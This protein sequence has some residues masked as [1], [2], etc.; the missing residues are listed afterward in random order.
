MN[1]SLAR[2]LA[3]A[4]G[5]VVALPVLSEAQLTRGIISGT[6]R[7][8]TSA[9]VPGAVATAINVATGVTRSAVTND[10][11]FY[12]IPALEP[13]QYL[14]KIELSGFK[15]V[16][17]TGVTVPM[18]TEVTVSVGLEVA[19]LGEAVTVTGEAEAVQLNKS[20]P[21]VGQIS[22][23]RQAVEL[24]LSASRDINNLALLAPNTF[25]APGST[26][27]S[28]NGQRA[29]NNNF[30]IDG[31]DNNDASVTISTLDLA[32]EAV[33]EFQVQTNP[34]NVE[35]GRNS[36]AQLNVV[37]KSGTNSFRGE[38]WDYYRSAGFNALDNREKANKLEEPTKN[39][40]HQA[41][42]S[43]GGPLVKDKLFFFGLFQ[44]DS[45]RTGDALGTAVSIPTQEGYAMLAGVPLR[46][47]QP[48]ASRQSILN[49][50]SFLQDVYSKNP[51]FTNPTTQ[52]VNG[53][54]IPF[55]T[56]S[57]GYPVPSTYLTGLARI[58]WQMGPK[59]SLTL[60][61]TVNDNED[62]NAASN[63][64]FG[65]IF[66]GNSIVKDQNFAATQTHVFSG[67]LLNEL[68][69]SYIK[70]DLQFPENAPELPTGTI[71]G[72]WTVG[73]LSNFPQ[74]RVQNSWQI[75]DVVTW[76]TGRHNFKFGADVR[77]IDLDNSA[78]FDS[79]GTYTFSNFEA[80]MNNTATSLAQAL[81]TAS[82]NAKQWQVFLF[83]QDDF[84]VSPDLVLNLGIRYEVSEAPFGFFGATEPEV[85]AALVPGPAKSDKNNWAPRVGFAW[86]PSSGS[87]FF[88]DGKFVMRGGYGISYD[89]LFYNILTV[90][91]SNYPRV[92]VGQAFNVQDVY[93]AVAPTT[94]AAVFN[95]L[96]TFVNSPEDLQNPMTHFYSL[97]AQ[98]EFWR[99]FVLEVGYTGSTGRSA[100]GQLQ[101]N[102]AVLTAEQAETVRRTGS[103][104]SIPSVQARRLF[105]QYGSRVIIGS[106][107]DYSKSQYHAGFVSLQKRMSHGLQ[108]G[109]SYTRSQYKSDND[110]SLG[111]AAITGSSPQI[112]QDYANLDAEWSL[113]VFDR[114]NRFV[115][116]YIYEIPGVKDGFL[117][118]V[119][120]GW[121]IAGVTQY[122]S[123]QPF[124][125]LTGI[126]TNGNGGGG[127]RPNVASGSI[128]WSDGQKEFTNN[129]RYEVP[130]GANGLP[131]LYSLG[132][133]TG[134]RNAERGA[135]FWRTDLSLLK[136]FQFD[137]VWLTL[138]AD[139]LNVFNQDRYDNPT[140]AMNST[141]FGKNLNNWGNRSITLAA[142]L[143]F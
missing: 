59:D 50:L 76:N 99:D 30:T 87:G 89:V 38:L 66:C 56:T 41:G 29:R 16:E 124:T 108:F 98:R 82:F 34:Y 130:L 67:T 107:S 9:L 54:N 32:P 123:G 137:R 101:A 139:A 74:G 64:V 26:G 72:L 17:R 70:R 13:G 52:R 127:D 77:H 84:R 79:K 1:R 27:I 96:A 109:L 11:G 18:S 24:P 48:A 143:S 105:P 23:A 85:Q 114:P 53:V 116:N 51:V 142:K 49:S 42:A 110:E 71:S 106:D 65:A 62:I 119:T 138:R 19:A 136:R 3:L 131:L 128:T 91:A 73:G 133:G 122:Q 118:W 2:L 61:Y 93:P 35:F 25:T 14:V 33:A 102:Y 135:P 7:D 95:P 92:V 20:N 47:G 129:G 44:R 90:N 55:G 36:G 125:V 28:A 31:S 141:N 78:A 100:V 81:Q 68:R 140:T 6:V 40:R 21:T 69:V 104:T 22:T 115:V 63:C 103:S 126:D 80:F 10:Q 120:D 39:V 46:A 88:N 45:I 5:V 113:S 111:V 58:D 83:A 8:Q 94:G 134:A 43:L 4:F 60:R 15:T 75:Q 112:P 37:T 12:R 86:S 121:Q 97:S 132:N 117:K 57:V